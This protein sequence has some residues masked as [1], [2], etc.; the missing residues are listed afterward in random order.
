MRL[1]AWRN[2]G[3][4]GVAHAPRLRTAASPLS[5][6]LAPSVH[7]HPR[8]RAAA[9]ARKHSHAH[10]R[11]CMHARKHARTRHVL[12]RT[13]VSTQF[14]AVAPI[15]QDP[16][17]NRKRIERI[18]AAIILGEAHKV[19]A[20]LASHGLS[21]AIEFIQAILGMH[22]A[23]KTACLVDFL[24][25]HGGATLQ[26]LRRF[27]PNNFLGDIIGSQRTNKCGKCHRFGHIQKYCAW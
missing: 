17:P 4:G 22:D 24:F 25:R 13:I 3:D 27:V 12:P 7:P 5:R 6:T 21:L 9:C 15:L 11:A 16:R 23:E 14:H 1:G 19:H 2:G 26:N 8:A 20:A 10:T 18:Q